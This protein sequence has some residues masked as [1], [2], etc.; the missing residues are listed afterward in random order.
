MNTNKNYPAKLINPMKQ[1]KQESKSI[2]SLTSHQEEEPKTR[3][4]RSIRNDIKRKRKCKYTTTRTAQEH[5]LE[6]REE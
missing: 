2:A 1:K 5:G 4:A 6:R 3:R